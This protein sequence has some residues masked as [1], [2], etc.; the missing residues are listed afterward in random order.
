M[1]SQAALSAVLRDTTLQALRKS[2]S[3]D[4]IV[5]GAGAAGGLA[6]MLL[7]ERGLRVL[8]LDAGPPR[9]FLRTPLR[10]LPGYL[11]RR[12]ATTVPIGRLPAPLIPKAQEGLSML[13]RWRQP[14]QSHCSVWHLSPNSY[15]DDRD[16]SSG[17]A[18]GYWAVAL[19]SQAMADNITG[20]AP[21]I[22]RRMTG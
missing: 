18:P 20:S 21:T 4:A 22:L 8:V 5:V 12:L 15:V 2:E 9:T 10:R 3:H 1:T 16:H 17:Y 6:A 13:G 7:A 11:V 14:V 19:Q